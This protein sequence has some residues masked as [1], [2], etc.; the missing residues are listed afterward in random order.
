MKNW[1][2]CSFIENENIFFKNKKIKYIM[3]HK[4]VIMK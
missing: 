4:T 1:K 3:Y 2:G